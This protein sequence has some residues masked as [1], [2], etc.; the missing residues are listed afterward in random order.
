MSLDDRERDE[1]VTR[2][3]RLFALC[4]PAEQQRLVAA[5]S[6]HGAGD[7]HLLAHLANLREDGL[8]DELLGV[9]HFLRL[10][11]L[12]TAFDAQRDL[13]RALMELTAACATDARV[14]ASRRFAA[15][16]RCQLWPRESTG[17]RVPRDLGPHI[18]RL[19]AELAQED[20]PAALHAIDEHWTRLPPSN[21]F[22]PVCLHEHPQLSYQLAI[23]FRPDRPDFATEM[24]GTSIF[25]A[26]F[27]LAKVE[28]DAAAALQRVMD[29]SCRL[30]AQWTLQGP[31]LQPTTALRA[32]AILFRFGEPTQ[33]YWRELGPRCLGT[34]RGLPPSGEEDRLRLLANVV[35]YADAGDPLAAE[36]LS[37]LTAAARRKLARDPGPLRPSDRSAGFEAP[38]G[39]ICRAILSVLEDKLMSGRNPRVPAQPEH[40]LLHT[41]DALVDD[42]LERVLGGQTPHALEH[43]ICVVCGLSHE[44]LVRKNHRILRERFASLAR[45]DPV[46]AGLALKR[47]VQ[48]CGYS[49]VDDEMYRKTL[50]R[51]SFDLLLPTLEAI[52][53]ADATV[54]R[55][56]IGRRPWMPF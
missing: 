44:T 5:A 40:V 37:M 56:G 10:L 1:F 51:E 6:W 39:D 3:D 2:R 24:L 52:S 46:D 49:Q 19:L 48:Y 34:M 14:P 41:V 27:L 31:A 23:Q 28:P 53:P 22:S 38:V 54:A 26:S 25:D 50:C 15:A 29:A 8:A 12:R 13:D 21:L 47:L 43:W 16:Q 4:T 42:L 32:L 55:T 30:L 20:G 11:P 9:V 18:W 7:Q 35:F 45:L 36:A 33:P 17:W